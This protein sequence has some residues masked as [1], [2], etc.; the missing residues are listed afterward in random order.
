MIAEIGNFLKGKECR[1]L[2]SHMRVS[3]P[4]H[5]T[6]MYPDL[7]IVCGKPELEDE[8]FDTLLNPS[9]IFEILS[10][11]TYHHDKRYKFWHYQQILSLKEFFMLES[12]QRLV[13][14]ARKQ[15]DGAWRLLDVPKIANEIHIETIDLKISFDSIY[16][17]TGL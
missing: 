16:R 5:E 9:V 7:L 12:R 15:K 2:P 13:Q 14:I 10:P 11:S 3:T 17:D 6:Y 1:V 8:Q 4:S